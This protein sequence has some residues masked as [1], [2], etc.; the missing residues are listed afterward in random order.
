MATITLNP[1]ENLHPILEAAIHARSSVRAWPALIPSGLDHFPR[2]FSKALLDSVTSLPFRKLFL[3][4]LVGCGH[5]AVPLFR[6]HVIDGEREYRIYMERLG[7][8]PE[9]RASSIFQALEAM[10]EGSAFSSDPTARALSK[11]AEDALTPTSGAESPILD[12]GT[13]EKVRNEDFER[14]HAVSSLDKADDLVDLVEQLVNRPLWGN[15]FDRLA[16]ERLFRSPAIRRW[17]EYGTNINARQYFRYYNQFSRNGITWNDVVTLV[18]WPKDQAPLPDLRGQS[19]PRISWLS[20]FKDVA[21]ARLEQSAGGLERERP[22]G[23]AEQASSGPSP[24]PS[25]SFYETARRVH[26]LAHHDPTFLMLAAGQQRGGSMT[27]DLL[28]IANRDHGVESLYPDLTPDPLWLA[29]FAEVELP[30]LH[31]TSPVIQLH[32]EP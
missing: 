4:C 6:E 5:D 12:L 25:P 26:L 27:A 22:S 9:T 10:R 23:G 15:L 21:T 20:P 19:I 16:L 14:A 11:A 13:L 30:R 2:F 17:S 8:R 24:H 18:R 1:S 3:E 31:G 32:A 29:W 28:A 7:G